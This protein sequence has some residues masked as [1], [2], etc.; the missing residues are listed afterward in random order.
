MVT[1]EYLKK[2]FT[3]KGVGAPEYVL[4]VDMRF[5]EG[6]EDIFTM[7][8]KTYVQRI[9]KQFEV[10]MG[11]LPPKKVTLP[12]EPRDHPELDTSK[13]L[14]E[15]AKRLYWS[16]LGMLQWAVTIGRMDIHTAVMTMGRFRAEPR[17]G[18]L[19]RIERIYAFLKYYK[20]SSIKF[21]TEMPDYSKY[22][23]IDYD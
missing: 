16:L 11:Y 23:Q 14:D 3:L 8:S 1:I 6:G 21:R 17:E 15:K 22:H 9:L 12:I 4:G 13:P 20:S 7:G 19:K 5:N 18:H 10:M 2:Q